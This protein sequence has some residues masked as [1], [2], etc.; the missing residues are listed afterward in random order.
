MGTACGVEGYSGPTTV[1]VKQLKTNADENERREFIA[2]MDIMKQVFLM[3]YLLYYISKIFS[4]S[5]STIDA[6]QV[7]KKR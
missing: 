2:E 1:A 5:K 3:S 4:C 6:N 7:K